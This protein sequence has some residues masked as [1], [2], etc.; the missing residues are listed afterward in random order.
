MAVN[1]QQNG[2]GFL[3]MLALVFI[4]LKLTEVIDWSWWWVTAPLWGIL[5]LIIAVWVLVLT[6]AFTIDVMRHIAGRSKRKRLR[7]EKEELDRLRH[8]F[9]G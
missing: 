7:E 8:D 9:Q 5:A 6:G 4:T 3:G 1:N 2:I